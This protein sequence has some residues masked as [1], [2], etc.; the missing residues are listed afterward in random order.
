MLLLDQMRHPQKPAINRSQSPSYSTEF[1]GNSPFDDLY[2]FPTNVN[3]PPP[4]PPS[5]RGLNIMGDRNPSSTVTKSPYWIATWPRP[6]MLFAVLNCVPSRRLDPVLSGHF[7]PRCASWSPRVLRSG[8]QSAS[9]CG[10][11]RMYSRCSSVNRVVSM[12]SPHMILRTSDAV[13]H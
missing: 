3:P 1:L 13:P 2:V 7:S 12:T 11:W 8:R 9:L 10:P 4:S 6:N 5:S